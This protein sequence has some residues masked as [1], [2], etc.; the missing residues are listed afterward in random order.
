MKPALLNFKESV[1]ERIKLINSSEGLLVDFSGLDSYLWSIKVKD[2]V[3]IIR[4]KCN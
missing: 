2:F 1:E 4:N 3:E